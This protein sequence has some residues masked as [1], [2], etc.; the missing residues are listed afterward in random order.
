MGAQS[1]VDEELKFLGR[2]HDAEGI[3]TAYELIR[4]CGFDNVSLDLMFGLPNQTV[5]NLGYSINEILKLSTEKN[6]L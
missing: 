1:F 3:R 4:K 5:E 6:I 2:L